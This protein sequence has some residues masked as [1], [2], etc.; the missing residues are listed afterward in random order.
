[1]QHTNP[2]TSFVCPAK[3]GR[4]LWGACILE[5]ALLTCRTDNEI[6]D[7]KIWGLW[8]L[9]WNISNHRMFWVGRDTGMIESMWQSAS[10]PLH[11]VRRD[12]IDS[13]GV[14]KRCP[15]NWRNLPTNE[16]YAFHV[17]SVKPLPV[18]PRQ[19]LQLDSCL[20]SAL[21]MPVPRLGMWW[22]AA[23]ALWLVSDTT[24]LGQTHKGDE[25]DEKKSFV[26]KGDIKYS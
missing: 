6:G 18:A 26:L 24:T 16:S 3:L 1:M 14:C 2:W 5:M 7:W 23:P 9:H 13:Q 8:L 20:I 21:P 11:Q 22:P 19:H 15:Q 10:E 25:I 12:S 4:G 17:R